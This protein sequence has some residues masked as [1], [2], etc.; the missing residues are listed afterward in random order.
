MTRFKCIPPSIAC[1]ADVPRRASR[2]SSSS[3]GDSAPVSFSVVIISRPAPAPEEP[4]SAVSA[5]L[6]RSAARTIQRSLS[7]SALRRRQVA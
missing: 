2:R 7:S 6:S 1:N 3:T 5:S 4:P